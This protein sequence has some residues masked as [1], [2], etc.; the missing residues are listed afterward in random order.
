MN[1]LDRR[2]AEALRKEDAEL[3][4]DAGESPGV[5]DMLFETFRGKHRWL[6]MLGAIWM[7][8]FL[9]LAAAAAAA[10]FRAEATRDMLLWSSA[11]ILCVAAVAMLKVWYWMEIQRIA[12]MREIKR[13][14]LQIAQLAAR[15][16]T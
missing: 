1:E 9:V 16:G 8:V 10:F 5:L 15:L 3:F 7:V 11:C 4:Q 13:V 12:V 2:I 6:N 14:E